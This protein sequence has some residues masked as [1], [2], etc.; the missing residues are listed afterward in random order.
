MICSTKVG[1]EWTC[2]IST[3][4]PHSNMYVTH[5]STHSIIWRLVWNIRVCAYSNVVIGVNNPSN[6]CIQSL[7]NLKL[8]VDCEL[9]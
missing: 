3:C 8:I 2:D 9:K 6:K 1:S 5:V 7:A 4:S